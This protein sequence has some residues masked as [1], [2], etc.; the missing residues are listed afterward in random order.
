ME[1]TVQ[2]LRPEFLWS[3]WLWRTDLQMAAFSLNIK[4]I[5]SD[6][7]LPK[8]NKMIYNIFFFLHLFRLGKI[9]HDYNKSKCF[10]TTR[11]NG[12]VQ[13]FKIIVHREWRVSAASLAAGS[14]CVLLHRLNSLVRSGLQIVT[15]PS[16]YLN[17]VSIIVADIYLLRKTYWAVCGPMSGPWP[18]QGT[19]TE[20]WDHSNNFSWHFDITVPHLKVPLCTKFTSPFFS[21]NNLCP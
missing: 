4:G 18:Q 12:K 5:L 8:T 13:G 6:L 17:A 7:L 1:S 10:F 2:W 14:V 21:N 16:A 3:R 9:S 19:K 15:S 11:N 20:P